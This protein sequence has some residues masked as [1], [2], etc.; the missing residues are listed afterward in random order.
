MKILTY[1]TLL[2]FFVISACE[3]PIEEID[4]DRPQIMEIG[5][6][7][8]VNVS[9]VV[10]QKNA[11]SNFGTLFILSEGLNY[12]KELFFIEGQGDYIQLNLSTSL[13]AH[14]DSGVYRFN[15][16]FGDP[17]TITF[18]QLAENYN[19]GGCNCSSI[20]DVIMEIN[21]TDGDDHFTID[22]ISKSQLGFEIN[23]YYNGQ[24]TYSIF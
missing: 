19:N 13:G 22:F 10:F 7:K 2:F 1:C 6:S 8:V 14:L 17:F 20:V 21:A 12:N 24:V 11:F 9:D 18:G 23:G 15:Q 16:F 4:L 3:K 5:D